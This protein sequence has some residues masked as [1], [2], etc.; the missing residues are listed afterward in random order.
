MVPGFG[1]IVVEIEP[2]HHIVAAGETD[3]W[4]L[5]VEATPDGKSRLIS[6]WRQD[7]PRSLPAIVWVALADAVPS[8]WSG[9]CSGVSAH[10][11]ADA[12]RWNSPCARGGDRETRTGDDRT[13][14]RLPRRDSSTVSCDGRDGGLAG[15]AMPND[16]MRVVVDTDMGTDDVMALLFLLRRPDVSV[17]AVTMDGDGLTHP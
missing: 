7:W 14:G 8:S 12:R 17:T 15:G 13:R 10:W 4:C 6:R 5:Q 11:P 9:G 1:P 3:S 16:T 2:D